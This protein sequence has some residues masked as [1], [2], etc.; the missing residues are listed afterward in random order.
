MKGFTKDLIKSQI[1]LDSSFT[2]LSNLIDIIHSTKHNRDICFNFIT[3]FLY[4]LYC[5]KSAFPQNDAIKI[6]EN[7]FESEYKYN[8]RQL[9]EYIQQFSKKEYESY[10]NRLPELFPFLRFKSLNGRIFTEEASINRPALFDFLLDAYKYRLLEKSP[11][12]WTGNGYKLGFELLEISLTKLIRAFKV[13]N[14]NV[15]KY[16]NEH[17]LKGIDNDEVINKL[18][19][20][21]L[22]KVIVIDRNNF[23]FEHLKIENHL[24]F[25]PTVNPLQISLGELD[26]KNIQKEFYDKETDNNF[27]LWANNDPTIRAL[28]E[29]ALGLV[30]IHASGFLFRKAIFLYSPNGHTGKTTFADY[31]KTLVGEDNTSVLTFENLESNNNRFNLVNLTGK[32]LNYGDEIGKNKTL[33]SDTIAT[34]KNIFNCNKIL[35]EKKGIDGTISQLSCTFLYTCNDIPYFNDEALDSRLLIIPFLHVFPDT[36]MRNKAQTPSKIESTLKYFFLMGL[37][38]ALRLLGRFY[39]QEYP[40]TVSEVANKVR[41]DIKQ[42]QDPLYRYIKEHEEDLRSYDKEYKNTKQYKIEYTA[43]YQYKQFVDYCE[44]NGYYRR[45]SPPNK[46]SFIDKVEATLNMKYEKGDFRSC[47]NIAIAKGD[48]NLQP[49]VFKSK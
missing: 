1:Q 44:S 8:E 34:L 36:D 39:K 19:I 28:L 45:K 22:D 3:Y 40:F 29:E 41:D 48:K 43:S 27:N 37:K 30:L 15:N 10:E 47:I 23:D 49:F 5:Y 31:V 46:T 38:G 7:E 26:I 18:L 6:L 14:F 35:T 13:C 32:R 4:R 21:C 9:K 17:C 12:I 25:K 24:T 42:K 20:P 2:H 11:A 16:M 33:D